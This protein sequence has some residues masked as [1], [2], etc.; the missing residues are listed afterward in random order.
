MRFF[1][2]ILKKSIYAKTSHII[3]PR[4]VNSL[5]IGILTL[6]RYMLGVDELPVRRFIG[7]PRQE[8]AGKRGTK[9]IGRRG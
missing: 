9:Q 1:Q 8:A 4:W 3:L 2:S 5:L 7:L 6:E